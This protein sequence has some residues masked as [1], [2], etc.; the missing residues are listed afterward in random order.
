MATVGGPPTSLNAARA[1]YGAGPGSLRALLRGAGLV[2][3]IP[4]NAGVPT[5][6]NISLLQLV[7]STNY[8]NIAAS[9]SKT[10]GETFRNEPAPPTASVAGAL[11]A[12]SITGGTGSYSVGWSLVSTGGASGFTWSQGGNTVNCSATIGKFDVRTPVFRL[13]ISDG[14]SVF[15]QD[16]NCSLTYTTDL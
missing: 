15:Q 10:G 5:S 6:G 16:Y 9:V 12:T 2:P 8:V 13:T 4:A 7:G 1:V 14:V 3:N 11:T